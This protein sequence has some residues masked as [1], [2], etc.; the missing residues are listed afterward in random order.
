MQQS[1]C[2]NSSFWLKFKVVVKLF[3]VPF[4]FSD[5]KPNKSQDT[6]NCLLDLEHLAVVLVVILQVSI[7]L[8]NSSRR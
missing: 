1:L 2:C 3:T 8:H 6:L 7:I 4:Y 5:N